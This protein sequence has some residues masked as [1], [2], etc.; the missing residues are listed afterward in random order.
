MSEPQAAPGALEKPPGSAIL[1]N[2][3]GGV[4]RGEVLRVQSKYFHIQCFVCKGEHPGPLRGGRPHGGVGGR[5]R[6]GPASGLRFWALQCLRQPL[7]SGAL[8]KLIPNLPTTA[9]SFQC[10]PCPLGG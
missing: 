3:C 6:A 1:C 8:E 4:C 2:T 10:G 7:R 9:G 5:G